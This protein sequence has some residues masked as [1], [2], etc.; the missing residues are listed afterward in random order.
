MKTM[1]VVV[2]LLVMV[3]LGAGQA[4]AY[5]ACFCVGQNNSAGA[6]GHGGVTGQFQDVRRSIPDNLMKYL[7]LAQ[8]LRDQLASS[9]KA[10][11]ATSGWA[12][13]KE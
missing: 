1:L 3:A 11:D 2:M 7:L 12:C 9:G 10:Y 13:W 6:C 5:S 4:F 8:A